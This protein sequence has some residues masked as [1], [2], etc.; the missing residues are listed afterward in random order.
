M[1][2]IGIT[3]GIGSG[4]TTVCKIWE[5]MGARVVY[6][7]DLA[8]QMMVSDAVIRDKIKKA[9]GNESYY[10]DGSL[11]KKYLATEAFEKGRVEEFNRIVHPRVIARTHELAKQAESEGISVFVK[12]AA[13]LLKYGRPEGIDYIVVV[14][15]PVSERIHRVMKRDQSEEKHVRERIQ[16][17]QSQEDLLKYADIEIRNNG[18]IDE[19]KK[20]TG[21][22]YRKF[23]KEA[24]NKKN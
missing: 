1:I 14:T 10:P 11:N 7:D 22:L 18:S 4:K 5:T 19:L 16:K 2:K 9:F 21:S 17:Q 6:A 23:E 8:K 13:L 3:G 12:E 15:A 20:Q 24:N